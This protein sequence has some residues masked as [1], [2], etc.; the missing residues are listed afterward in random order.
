MPNDPFNVLII[1]AG[2]SGSSIAWPLLETR[3]RILCF[4]QSRHISDQL[5]PLD[6][7]TTNSLV[8]ATSI[9]IQKCDSFRKTI[10]ST[11]PTVALCRSTGTVSAVQPSTSS[12]IGCG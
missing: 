11:S 2:T 7:M 5:F 9:A 3:N 12:D 10:L 1:G 4:E 6:G 8:T